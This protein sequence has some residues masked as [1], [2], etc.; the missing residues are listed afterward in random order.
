MKQSQKILEEKGTVIVTG[1]V[2]TGKTTFCRDLANLGFELGFKIAIVDCDLGQSNI[3]TPG[4]IGLGFLNKTIESIEEVPVHSLYFVGSV[5]PPGYFLP[6]VVGTK[7]MVEKAKLERPDLI[8]IDTSGFIDGPG[9]TLKY[10]KIELVKPDHIVAFQN[11][12]ELENLLSF[13]E[14]SY[15]IYRFSVSEKVKR[16]TIEER[17][18]LRENK[19][20][21]YFREAKIVDI[22]IDKISLLKPIPDKENLLVAFMDENNEV[23]DLGIVKEYNIEKKIITLLTPL[24]EIEKIKKIQFGEVKAEWNGL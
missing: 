21:R 1:G 2:D 12:D 10:Y 20:K 9:E 5:S 7:K 8:I 13:L 15:P 22:P 23:L 16:R 17:R 3:G 11:N 6:T 19:F 4:T 14:D 18:V 24:K